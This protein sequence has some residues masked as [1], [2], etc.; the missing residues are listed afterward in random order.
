MALNK[1]GIFSMY[2]AGQGF[3][4]LCVCSRKVERISNCLLFLGGN[5]ICNTLEQQQ[6]PDT[7]PFTCCH[8]SVASTCY[9]YLL[10]FTAVVLSLVVAASTLHSTIHF[11]LANILVASITA[12]LGIQLICLRRF[13]NAL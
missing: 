5:A 4:C 7:G 11:V 1:S 12:Y 6:A 13:V 8:Q 9:H 2:I 10:V 3:R